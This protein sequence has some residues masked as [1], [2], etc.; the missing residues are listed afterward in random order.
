MKTLFL[1]ALILLTTGC[2]TEV[3][4]SY[5]T[6]KLTASGEPGH[7]HGLLGANT[8]QT[9]GMTKKGIS[10][11][12]PGSYE[13]KSGPSEYKLY[14]DEFPRDMDLKVFVGGVE[15]RRGVD[16]TWSGASNST[17]ELIFSVK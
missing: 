13:L 6:I 14:L 10:W 11:Q 9:A 4:A 1:S 7:V 12:C 15:L 3:P 5:K 8:P 17:A 16:C 2:A